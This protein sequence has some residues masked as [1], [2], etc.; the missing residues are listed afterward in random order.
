MR[1]RPDQCRVYAAI[2]SELS[3]NAR[4]TLRNIVARHYLF[5]LTKRPSAVLHH[6]GGEFSMFLVQRDLNL[7]CLFVCLLKIFLNP[8]LVFL[9]MAPYLVNRF[10]PDVS[11]DLRRL[12]APE[13]VCRLQEFQMLCR[14]P[15]SLGPCSRRAEVI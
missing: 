15:V 9:C 13:L 10:G 6:Q 7:L 8:D 3:H 12:L 1:A 2:R 11:G 14:L 5:V 4:Q